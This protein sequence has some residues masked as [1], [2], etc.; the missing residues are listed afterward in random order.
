MERISG[1]VEEMK[2]YE[3]KIKKRSR[4]QFLECTKKELN[5]ED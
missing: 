1:H 5:R 3:C 2:G 4:G